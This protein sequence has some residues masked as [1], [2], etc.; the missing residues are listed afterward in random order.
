MSKKQVMWLKISGVCGILAPI[1]GFTAVWLSMFFA[2]EFNLANNAL[3]NL[4]TLP[5]PAVSVL[6]RLGAIISG[7]LG[8]LFSVSLYWALH[9]YEILSSTGRP[10]VLLVYRAL[11]GVLFFPVAYLA[12]ITLG[13]FPAGGVHRV[14]L[15]TFFV[16]MLLALGD[17][18]LGFWQVKQ[19]GLAWFSF[20][21]AV[22]Y[23]VPWLLLLLVPYVGGIA[24]PELASA[25]AVGLWMAVFGYLMLKMSSRPEFYNFFDKN[26]L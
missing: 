26:N 12:L 18:V 3:S 10:P 23:V 22:L 15:V 14:A 5:N 4:G 25:A 20:G 1:V 13:V 7:V 19:K 6:F 16:V 11:G 8:L 17:F 21:L 2:Q 9:F 24:V